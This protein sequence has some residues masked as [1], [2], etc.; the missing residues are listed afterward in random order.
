MKK[1]VFI[2]SGKSPITQTGGLGAYAWTVAKVFK[3]LDYDVKIFG[4][5]DKNSV[6]HTDFA[7]IHH[8]YSPVSKILVVGLPVTARLLAKRMKKVIEEEGLKDVI[9]F[10]C[11][12]WGL[13]GLYL[14]R[15]LK[16]SRIQF[17]LIVGYF[18]TYRHDQ[19]GQFIGTSINEYG[20][21]NFSI[22]YAIYLLFISTYS[23]ME[24]TLLLNADN[25]IVHYES[26]DKI[27]INEFRGIKHDIIKKIPYYTE[28]YERS[29]DI[30]FN[31]PFKIYSGCVIGVIC[32]QDPRKGISTFLKSL[33]ILNDRGIDYRCFIAGDGIFLKKNRKLA[34]RLGLESKVRFLGFVESV[35]P[36]LEA[37]DIYVLPTLEEGSG[38]ISL[39]EAMQYGIP[40]VTTYCD[41][42]PED[43]IDGE[44][45][46]LVPTKDSE[47]LADAIEK[48]IKEPELRKKL[49]KNVKEDYKK[50]F[51]FDKMREGIK[52]ILHEL[53]REANSING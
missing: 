38:A 15:K 6:A 21:I 39:L 40:I 8:V 17:N 41:G 22:M 45:A 33:K 23:W 16:R 36:Y 51:S 25:I 9:I 27:L 28:L 50:R 14:L 1:T 24:K 49:A 34:I 4:Y 53:E 13:A 42:I 29:S 32:R 7:A 52:N 31:D 3:S 26:T 44:T 48:L 11:G 19:W 12:C 20:F 18:S 10:G 35:E 5:C 43:F 37:S 47:S 30:G 46:L 2:I